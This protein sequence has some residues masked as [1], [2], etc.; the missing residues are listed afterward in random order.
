[1]LCNNFCLVQ[2]Q[3][4]K[5]IGLGTVLHPKT[6]I[7]VCLQGHWEEDER[8]GRLPGQ[9]QQPGMYIYQYTNNL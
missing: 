7:S 8:S 4:V 3:K 6:S 9:D 2:S 1:M 5:L